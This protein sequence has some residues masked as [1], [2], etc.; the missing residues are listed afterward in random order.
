VS[1]PRLAWLLLALAAGCASRATLPPAPAAPSA[2][3]P[4]PWSLAP[5]DAPSQRLFRVQVRRGAESGGMR[6]VLRLWSPLRFEIAASDPLGRPLWSLVARDERGAWRV[7]G[8]RGICRQDPRRPVEWPRLGLAL[9]AAHLPSILLGRLPEAPGDGTVI[10][11]ETGSFAFTD[12]AG[13]AWRA[14]LEAGTLVEWSLSAAA[15]DLEWRR[16]A[17][18]GRLELAA[19]RL[20]IRWREVA[21]EALRG[22]APALPADLDSAPE[23]S[24]EDLS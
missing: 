22:T 7:A 11:A 20:E 16:E 3:P 9:P 8:A 15:G 21:R 13:R 5:G 10:P 19:E 4:T 24:L 18:G 17:P 6:L 12:P 1:R 2:A 14:T 23:C